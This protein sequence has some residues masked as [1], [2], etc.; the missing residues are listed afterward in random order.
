MLTS[1][2]KLGFALRGQRDISLCTVYTAFTIILRRVSVTLAESG[3]PLNSLVRFI[4]DKSG[5]ACSFTSSFHT[6]KGFLTL[7]DLCRY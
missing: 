4:N 6:F 5:G 7:L 1:R 2:M 3:V